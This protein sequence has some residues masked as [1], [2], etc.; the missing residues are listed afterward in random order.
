MFKR[1]L[2]ALAVI[3]LSAH[4][5]FAQVTGATITGQVTDDSGEGLVGVTIVA[6]HTPSGTSYGAVSR[7]DGRYTLANLRVGG[8]Y[9]VSTTY[10]GYEGKK[11]EGI[12]LALGQK[13]PLE[14]SLKPSVTALG[15]VVVT[16]TSDPVLNSERTGASTNISRQQIANL[17][18]IGRSAADYTRLSPMAGEGNSFAGR[19]DQFNNFSLDGAIFNNPFGLDAATPGGQS[20]AQPVSL[21]AID[22][23]QVAYAP[24]DVTESGFTGAAINAVTKSGTN[25][26]IGS[27]FGF[28][29]NQDF[30]GSKVDKVDAPKGDLT[31]LQ[32]G[33]NLGG[34]VIKNKLFFFVNAEI[35]RRSD[36]GSSFIANRGTDGPGISRVLA[37]DLDAVSNALKSIGYDP[38][39]YENFTLEAPNLKG[40]AKLDWNISNNHKFSLTYNYL[41]ASQQK[42]AHPSAIGRRGPDF[43]TLQFR[44]AGYRINNKLNQVIGELKSSFGSSASNKFQLGYSTFRDNRDQTSTPAPTIQILK[45]GT[46]YIIAGHEPFSIY[47]NL[48][49]DV[50]QLNDN[51]NLYLGKH[52]LTVGAAYE[53][54]KFENAFNLGAYPGVFGSV[55]IPGTFFARDYLSVQE[56]LDSV[57]TGFVKK[58]FDAAK[59][60]FDGNNQDPLNKWNWSY[61]N[62]GQISAY[63]QDEFSLFENFSLTL[64]L[65]M[66]KPTYLNT[67]EKIEEKLK[68][69]NAADYQPD[70][71]YYDENGKGI[72]FD[73]T[74]LPDAKPLFNPRLGFNWDVKGDRSLQIRGGS[75]LFSGRFPFVWIGNQVANPNF[76]FYCVTRP[77]FKFPQVWRNNLGVDKKFGDG[78]VA[79]ADFIYTK[80]INGMMVRNYGLNLPT[81]RLSAPGDNRPVYTDADRA[82]NLFGGTT[83]AFVFTNTD[84]GYSTNLM[85]QLQRTWSNGMYG[86]LGYNYL[87]SRDASSIE[88]EISSDAYD[89]NPAYGNVNQAVESPSIYGYKHRVVGSFSKKFS[90]GG[91]EKNRF[92]TT[93]GLFFQYAQGGRFSYTYS[94]NLNNDGSGNNDLMYIPTDAEVDQMQFTGDAA[95]QRTA[96]KAFIAQDNYM[97]SHRGEVVEKYGILSPW[98]NNWDIRIAQ[99]LNHKAGKKMNT[100]Q[101]TVDILNAGNLISDSWGVRRIPS[102]TQPL[103]V[104]GVDA[105]GVPTFS[106]DTNIKDSFVQDFSLLSRWQMQLGLRYSF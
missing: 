89:R 80:D 71:Q 63:V 102:T 104:V 53:Q 5:L 19:N 84:V 20:N 87:D 96:F 93:I 101:F 54:F 14:V 37:S 50:L 106:F 2:G 81:G 72:K 1:L 49:Q 88:A 58:H 56:F 45:D 4:T 21:D 67:K 79:S 36:L 100:L 3:V 13:L 22:Q 29:R 46:R 10:T 12:M 42:P 8:P 55:P 24:Y 35:E 94:G 99:D 6:T 105:N 62:V 47:N 74:V 66:D 76:F 70:I 77:D 38:G 30:V 43:T 51:L 32:T 11:T 18:S 57:S 97:S 34:P 16:A 40:L 103:G 59:A 60:T 90:Y 31:Q 27:V 25:T 28:Y 86:S 15:E 9:T 41:D 39:A 52:T 33:F 95:A 65:R 23:I 44:N 83:D 17:P 26:F 75:G 7:A 64:G 85:L 91:T 61:T 98:F 73:H 69:P 78:W 68:T 48:N 92:G 82:K